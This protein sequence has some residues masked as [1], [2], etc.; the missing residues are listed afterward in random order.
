[1][2]P[3]AVSASVAEIVTSPEADKDAAVH[4]TPK[5]VVAKAVGKVTEAETTLLETLSVLV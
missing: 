1:V 3:L 5:Q 4:T 2:K